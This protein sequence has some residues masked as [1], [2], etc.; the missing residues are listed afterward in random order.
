VLPLVFSSTL[1]AESREELEAMMFFHPEQQNHSSQINASIESYGFPRVIEED[2][3]LRIGIEGQD[4]QTLYAFVKR[5]SKR[6]LVGVIVYT[7][8]GV[9]TLALLH[10]AVHPDYSH[11]SG[12]RNELI[13]PR[14]LEQLRTIAKRIRGITRLSIAYADKIIPRALVK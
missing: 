6:D 2:Q 14:M 5:G 10:M 13:L 3:Q 9:D 8:T 11:S 4:V 7:R 12:F 1:P